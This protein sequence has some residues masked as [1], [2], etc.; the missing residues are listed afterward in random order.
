MFGI[1]KDVREGGKAPPF[2]AVL[3]TV[4]KVRITRDVLSW[5]WSLL[6]CKKQNLQVAGGTYSVKQ[7]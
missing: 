2:A 3:W 5:T 1:V 6:N 4:V 7:D